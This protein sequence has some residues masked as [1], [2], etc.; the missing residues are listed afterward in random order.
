VDRDDGLLAVREL[1]SAGQP[2]EQRVLV[3]E[4]LLET[5]ARPHFLHHVGQV[6]D[7][8]RHLAQLLE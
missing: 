7:C 8:L 1:G 3:E 4:L 6:G 2:V 5:I